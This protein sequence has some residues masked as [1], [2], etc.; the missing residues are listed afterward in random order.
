[1]KQ[2]IILESD[3]IY[4]V[5]WVAPADG[6]FYNHLESQS[7]NV[8]YLKEQ[9]EGVG[10][11]LAWV[12]VPGQ[13]HILIQLRTMKKSEGLLIFSEKL[14]MILGL[15]FF[16]E[17]ERKHSA[18]WVNPKYLS[19]PPS[20]VERSFLLRNQLNFIHDVP[21]ALGYAVDQFDWPLSSAQYVHNAKW[22]SPLF[23]WWRNEVTNL[24]IEDS[25]IAQ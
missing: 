5:S 11:I 22:E 25:A 14:K 24:T 2:Q 7:L 13:C 1:M 3:Q 16:F 21:V 18:R 8:D 6:L 12:M 15:A 4:R 9:M 17:T 19:C 23:Y 10:T 20:G